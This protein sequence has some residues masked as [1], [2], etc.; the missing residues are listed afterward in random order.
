MSDYCKK[1]AHSVMVKAVFKREALEVPKKWGTTQFY[2]CKPESLLE[3]Q[4][5]N[6]IEL[7]P[8]PIRGDFFKELGGGATEF[9]PVM[10]TC[11]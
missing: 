5:K 9:C 4:K 3:W 2:F 11:F 10:T 6:K 1:Q 8:L 7:P